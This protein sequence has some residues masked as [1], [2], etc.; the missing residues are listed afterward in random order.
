MYEILGGLAGFGGREVGVVDDDA[1][2]IDTDEEDGAEDDD[3][4]KDDDEDGA[5]GEVGPGGT[6]TPSLTITTLNSFDRRS[7]TYGS[8]T[9]C[10]IV[11]CGPRRGM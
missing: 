7:I 8:R 4:D 9:L 2:G 3:A 11:V 10:K 5:E 1:G 6:G